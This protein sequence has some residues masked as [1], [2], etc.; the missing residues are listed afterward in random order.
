MS[1]PASTT[2]LSFAEKTATDNIEI[3]SSTGEITRSADWTKADYVITVTSDGSGAFAAGTFDY[4]VNVEAYQTTLAAGDV[5]WDKA[6]E[7]GVAVALKT[8]TNI[9]G[10]TFEEKEET[11]NIAINATTGEITRSEGWTKADYVVVVKSDGTGLYAEDT[12][13]VEVTV[14]V[15]AYAAP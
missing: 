11:A 4:T 7:A 13:G 2:G 14:N 6:D 5:A 8:P 9:T 10:L 1:S 12:T 15:E 3:N